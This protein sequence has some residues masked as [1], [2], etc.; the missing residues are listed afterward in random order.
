M[1]VCQLF[2]QDAN[3][4]AGKSKYTFKSRLLLYKIQ[5]IIYIKM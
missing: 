2:E 3:K 1:F 5:I 4:D